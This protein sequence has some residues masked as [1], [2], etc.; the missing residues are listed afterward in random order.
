MATSDVDT[1]SWIMLIS[2]QEAVIYP[3]HNNKKWKDTSYTT[4][5][6]KTSARTARFSPS[7]FKA[8]RQDKSNMYMEHLMQM[9]RRLI[10]S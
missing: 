9:S 5:H 2:T 8:H 1:L 4:R 10:K 7:R 6:N 3:K